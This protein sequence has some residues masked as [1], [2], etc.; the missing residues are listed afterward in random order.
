MD[1]VD[2]NFYNG[3]MDDLRIYNKALSDGRL[4]L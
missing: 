3:I 2:G 4:K 1:S